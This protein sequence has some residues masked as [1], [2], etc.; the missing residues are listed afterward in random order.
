[1]VKI[2]KTL[3][4]VLAAFLACW[5]PGI[6]AAWATPFYVDAA[7]VDDSLNDCSDPVQGIPPSGP[8]KSITKGLTVAN[9]APN[10]PHTVNVA[11]G[12]YSDMATGESFPLQ[13]GDGV[14]VIGIYGSSN[15]LLTGANGTA[16]VRYPANITMPA[17]TRLEGFTITNNSGSGIL[18]KPG[19]G[20]AS[21]VIRYD[22]ITGNSQHGIYIYPASGASASPSILNNTISIN[23]ASGIYIGYFYNATSSPTI[24][25]NDISQNIN[26]GITMYVGGNATVT[27]IISNNTAI[28]GNSQRG[29]FGAAFSY[30]NAISTL[31][32]TITN[33]TINNNILHGIELYPY[34]GTAG[35]PVIANNAS[36]AGNMQD[37]IFIRAKS[38]GGLVSTSFPTVS[39]NSI[40]GNSGRG[41]YVRIY[42]GG[43]VSP[44]IDNNQV[45]NNMG[46]GVFVYA[47]GSN[48]SSLAV[49]SPTIT[50]NT[51]SGNQGGSG[52]YFFTSYGQGLAVI[53]SNTAITDNS[54]RGIFV[55]ADF[56]LASAVIS[57]NPVISGNDSQAVYVYARNSVVTSTITN[58]T[59]AADPFSSNYGL[60][61]RATDNSTFT[62]SVSSNAIT[63]PTVGLKLE[64]QSSMVSYNFSNNT[65]TSDNETAF[66]VDA[67]N[68]SILTSTISN[69][70]ITGENTG[71]YARVNNNS[72]MSPTVSRNTISGNTYYGAYVYAS[73]GGNFSGPWSNNTITSAQSDG[74]RLRYSSY[75][76]YSASAN[77]D[78]GGG[79]SGSLGHN[80][81]VGSSGAS[82]LSYNGGS[83]LYALNNWWSPTGPNISGNVNFNPFNSQTLSFA[84]SPVN[85]SAGAPFT[86][87]AQPGTFFKT[88]IGAAPTKIAVTFGGVPATNL[89]VN[90]AETQV[91]GNAPAGA[92]TVDVAVTNPAGQTGTA[93]GA[94][95]YAGA[96]TTI[97]PGGGTITLGDTTLV[98]FPGTFDAPV[99]VA[100]AA[101]SAIPADSPGL[102]G[103]GAA[104]EITV[105]LGVH[106]LKPASLKLCYTNAQAAGKDESK[107]VIAFHNPVNTL[108][109]PLASSDDPVA[110]CVTA[111]VPH[112]TLFQVMS[113][114]PS[115]TVSTTKMFPNPF[116]PSQG[117]TLVTFTSVPANARIRIYTMTGGLIK[118]IAATPA[119]VASW[120]AT[121]QSGEKVASGVYF[122]FVQGAGESRTFKVA[123]QR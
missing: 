118:D 71:F 83:Y 46:G 62:P 57:N 50:N 116:R 69:N 32:P 108:W 41:I 24:V 122:A 97:P 87:T 60:Y 93:A 16:L 94:F 68:D 64:A 117:H 98:I 36:I 101:P 92:G 47:Q 27:P 23:S 31:S 81:I 88:N 56:G 8:C 96:Q 17:E 73:F 9:A 14:S 33:N 2:E 113:A 10:P 13:P 45:T 77:P 100:V 65:I 102:E 95:S 22:S 67:T 19:A 72:I 59:I 85:G 91:T 38:S 75:Y 90:A 18:I 109:F 30:A 49:S 53:S 48:P 20:D 84:V 11:T 21:P 37:G 54:S 86:I 112:F 52:I 61:L 104:V 121:N 25:S 111:F 4:I 15:T 42:S 1:M 70:T 120:D 80:T 34:G 5:G 66:Y 76:S 55:R 115:Q 29:I 51:I 63:S 78:L 26:S 103:L 35:S 123:V 7:T 58:N 107:F 6:P 114:G 3:R 89:A 44:A 74:M 110:N 82:D 99:A 119:G 106:L 12:T 43:E 39:N 40:T 105:P 28:S 79:A